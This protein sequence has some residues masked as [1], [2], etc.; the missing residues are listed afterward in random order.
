[1]ATNKDIIKEMAVMEHR[2]DSMEEKLDKMDEKL[3]MLTEKLLD[4]DYGVVARVNR[5][6]STRKIISKAVW[7]LYAATI[8]LIVKMFLR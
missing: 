5:N 2:I 6:T 4:P 1:M 7:I 8:G 3:D